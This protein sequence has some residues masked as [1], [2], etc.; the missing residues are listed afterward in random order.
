MRE[1]LRPDK[2]DLQLRDPI[3]PAYKIKHLERIKARGAEV[4]IILLYVL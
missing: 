4:E 3:P 2:F 1:H